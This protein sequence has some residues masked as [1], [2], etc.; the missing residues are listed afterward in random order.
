MLEN[1][2][3]AGN[4]PGMIDAGFGL[5]HARV[6]GG[7]LATSALWYQRVALRPSCGSRKRCRD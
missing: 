4:A 6:A 5:F 7:L 2:S 3:G 1:S